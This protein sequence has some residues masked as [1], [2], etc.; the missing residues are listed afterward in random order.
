[1]IKVRVIL[2]D[3]FVYRRMDASAKPLVILSPGREFNLGKVHKETSEQ[4]VE[5]SLPDGRT[6]Y[7]RGTTKL[8]VIYPVTTS[9]S[10]PLY[11]S[12]DIS[13][14]VLVQLPARSQMDLV[15]VLE[16]GTGSWSLV[17][18]P[19][20]REGYL[21]PEVK[22][23]REDQKKKRG[24]GQYAVYGSALVLIG[25]FIRRF[26]T[27]EGGWLALEYLAFAGIVAGGG[28]IVYS[29]FLAMRAEA[30]KKRPARQNRK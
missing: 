23:K 17:R 10:S 28:L 2:E 26:L 22:F 5:A 7:I 19:D 1:M 24:A 20:G 18:L 27:S 3:A 8:R 14:S 16:T 13:S 15:D 21:P 29:F 6:G 4:W 30:A 12:A 9:K 11:G 25:I